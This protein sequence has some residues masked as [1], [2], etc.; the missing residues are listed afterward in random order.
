MRGPL[1]IVAG[2]GVVVVVNLCVTA[3]AV[4]DPPVLEAE[5]PYEQGQAHEARLV[6]LRRS[7]ALGWKTRIAADS[8]GLTLTVRGRDDAPV[9]GLTGALT[10]KR[11]DRADQ[12]FD[13]PITEG[14]DGVYRLD[15]PINLPG[16]WRVSGALRQGD[17]DFVFG[18]RTWIQR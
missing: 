7:V 16:V 14:H 15:G 1:S 8:V 17:T 13:A 3:L 5:R 18:E 11:P 4:G 9:R 6:A 12:D 2:L 10:L